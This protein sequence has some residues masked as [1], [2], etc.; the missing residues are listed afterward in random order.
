MEENSRGHL[1][2]L[3]SRALGSQVVCRLPPK[4][5]ELFDKG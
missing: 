1:D 3:A 4:G 5:R 2:G